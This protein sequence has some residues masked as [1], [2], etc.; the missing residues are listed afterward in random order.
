MSVKRTY[1][2]TITF[3]TGYAD[4]ITLEGSDAYNF[5]TQ[6]SLFLKDQ[7]GARGFEY[8]GTDKTV[9]S[10]LFDK[11]AK[12]VRSAITETEYHDDECQDA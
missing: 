1:T 10:F 6:W 4:A 7:D 3:K 12:V 2:V 5:Y 11:I 8:T 9:T